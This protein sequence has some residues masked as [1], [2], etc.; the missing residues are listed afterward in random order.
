MLS[1]D[2]WGVTN[3]FSL[4]LQSVVKLMQGLLQCMMRQVGAGEY[5]SVS[6]GLLKAQLCHRGYC[7][8]SSSP[9][10]PPLMSRGKAPF[11]QV[12]K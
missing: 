10:Q 9:P 12:L 1:Q 3:L 2:F 4:F 7:P 5:L 11:Q 6:L 8:S